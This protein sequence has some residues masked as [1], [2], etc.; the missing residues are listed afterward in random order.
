MKNIIFL[1][2]GEARTSPFNVINEERNMDVLDSYNKYV[3]N[4]EFKS[5]YNYK[6]YFSVDDLN[7]EDTLNYFQKDKIGNIYLKAKN[8]YLYNINNEI[9]SEEYFMDDYNKSWESYDKTYH[10]SPN[11]IAQHWK[12]LSCYNMLKNDNL[13]YDYIIRVRTDFKFLSNLCELLDFSFREPEFKIFLCWDWFALGKPD[14]MKCYCTG[15]ENNYGKYKNQTIIPDVLPIIKNFKNICFLPEWFYAP[16][17]QLFEMLFEYCNN[18]GL[19]IN[20]TIYNCHTIGFLHLFSFKTP[21]LQS[22][23]KKICNGEFHALPCLS[24]VKEYRR[25][26]FTLFPKTFWSSFSLFFTL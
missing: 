8:Y 25:H 3:F 5:K 23:N 2:T 12:I 1:F 4:D 16:E 17:K 26:L 21:I 11:S 18:N 7:I 19:D 22:K 15:L 10:K 13:S 24:S 6:I 20:K 9:P 14:M